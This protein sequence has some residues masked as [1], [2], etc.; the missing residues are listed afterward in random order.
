MKKADRFKKRGFYFFKKFSMGRFSPP[1]PLPCVRHWGKLSFHSN[2]FLYT[3]AL[4]KSCNGL[5]LCYYYLITL[6]ELLNPESDERLVSCVCILYNYNYCVIRAW[7]N[8]GL[9]FWYRIK[10]IIRRK[11]KFKNTGFAKIFAGRRK[12]FRGPH[13][14][15]LWFRRNCVTQ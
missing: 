13:V 3:A 10:N 8:Q 7:F 4:C 12:F 6:D 9:G 2:S 5:D 14:R 1:T 11:R 15:H